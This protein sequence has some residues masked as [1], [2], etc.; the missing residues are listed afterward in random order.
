MI[1][2]LT[3]LNYFPENAED[4]SN[5]KY[6]LYMTVKLT[7]TRLIKIIASCETVRLSLTRVG[8]SAELTTVTHKHWLGSRHTHAEATKTETFEKS[9]SHSEM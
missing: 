7:M 3:F 1:S 2:V 4:F 8:E 9:V 5:T 6:D